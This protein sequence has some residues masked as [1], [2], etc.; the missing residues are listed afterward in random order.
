[1]KINKILFISLRNLGDIILTTPVLEK[2]HEEFPEAE[3][4]VIAGRPGK[5]IFTA[6]PAVGRFEPD[7]RRKSMWT[8][9][10]QVA[11]LRRRRYDLVV[12]MKNSLIPYLVGAPRHSRLAICGRANKHKKD[13]H[14]SRLRGLVPNPFS[15]VKFFIP[16]G[17]AEKKYIEDIMNQTSGKRNVVIAPGS[18]SHMK[19]WGAGKYALLADRLISELGCTVFITGND[20]DKEVARCVIAGMKHH[21][22]DLTGKT[23]VAALAEL[24][25][26]AQLVI[27]NDSAPLHVA[28]AAGTPTVALFGPSDERKYGPLSE[29]SKVITTSVPCRP[30]E[31]ARC[32]RALEKGC[33]ARI[34]VEDVF[35]AAVESL[36]GCG[37]QRA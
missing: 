12:D 22:E 28:S 3:I 8:R 37:G 15:D 29:R 6:H 24:M 13:E 30:C 16:A 4:D 25:R 27:T 10:K 20:D 5:D 2:L 26:H 7:E 31:N 34:T 1:M 23:S 18:K 33:I 14:L 35:R 36:G 21:A 19:R 17:D 11:D 9:L 32:G